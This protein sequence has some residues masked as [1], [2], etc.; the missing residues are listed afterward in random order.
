MFVNV[1]WFFLSHRLPIA[2][3]AINRNIKMSVY[4][5]FTRLH[6][7]RSYE[8]FNMIQ[9]P[10][11]RTSS[12]RLNL[13]IEFIN[14]IR[15]INKERPSVIHAVTIKPIIFLGIVSIFFRIPFIASISG[16]GPAFLP[17]TLWARFRL[18]LIKAIY[19]LIFL[20]RNSRAICQSQY[21]ASVLL[22]NN[23][24]IEKKIIFAEG[25]GIDLLQY[26]KKDY[27]DNKTTKI[28]MASRLLKNKGV[29]EFCLAA[30][31]IQK[32]YNVNADF[33]LAGPV[34]LESI[35]SFSNNEIIELCTAN[36]IS[37]LGNRDDLAQILSDTDIFILPSYYA[38]GMPKV[39]LEA[40]ACSCAVITT[41]HP[42][43][44]DS[45]I[46]GKTGLLVE[47]KNT[48]ALVSS[49]LNLLSDPRLIKA[50][51]RQ[52]RELAEEKFCISK[53]INIHYDLYF[54]LIDLK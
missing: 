3:A 10:I 44:R 15:L 1:D 32:K 41:N 43:C 30:G 24:I 38:E 40:A 49:I 25:S 36:K 29:E 17:T 16:L 33:S 11:K 47:P 9:S 6:D 18:I 19:K 14:T 45:I 27:V 50:M 5:D 34:D 48:S 52:G 46:P 35:G 20:S 22:E 39:L 4:T 21:D 31:V 28:L 2:K 7:N 12:R 51:G 42:G 53:V 23:L 26:K 8:G 13:L 37:Y 54:S